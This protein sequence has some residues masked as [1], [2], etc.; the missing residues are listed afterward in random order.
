MPPTHGDVCKLIY[1]LLSSDRGDNNSDSLY[2]LVVLLG[3]KLS[4]YAVVLNASVAQV[5]IS[6]LLV[7]Y[8]QMALQLFVTLFFKHLSCIGLL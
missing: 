6:A 1:S 4:N 5:V 3:S 2:L 8:T 7:Y